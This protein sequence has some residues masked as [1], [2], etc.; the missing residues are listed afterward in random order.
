MTP[1]V[2]RVARD[3]VRAR[4][5]LIRALQPVRVRSV[6]QRRFVDGRPQTVRDHHARGAI[7][8]ILQ[9]VTHHSEAGQTHPAGFHRTRA[10]H[11]VALA[12]LPHLRLYVLEERERRY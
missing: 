11:P 5:H 12:L 9:Q 6:R 8:A 10:G 7:E 1:R 2:D 3:A 4:A